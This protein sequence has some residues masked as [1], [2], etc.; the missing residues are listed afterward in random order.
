MNNDK[1]E[2]QIAK[3]RELQASKNKAYGGAWEHYELTT[4]ADIMIAKAK[5]LKQLAM[6]RAV[7]DN[8]ESMADTLRDLVNYAIHTL[9]VL[10]PEPE[11]DTIDK[12]VIDDLESELDRRSAEWQKKHEEYI[13]N[14]SFKQQEYP[15][16]LTK[17]VGAIF[18]QAEHTNNPL[19]VRLSDDEAKEIY[20]QFIQEKYHETK[21][22]TNR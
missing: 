10:E 9:A 16:W 21:P 15:K 20:G 19:E 22:Q 4:L 12:D 11:F 18:A 14:N 5:R 8:G 13:R 2:L 6:A 3:C 7:D 1:Y 17:L